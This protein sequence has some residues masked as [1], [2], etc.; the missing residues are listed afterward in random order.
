M[1]LSEKDKTIIETCYLQKG[2]MALRILKEFPRKG[3]KRSTVCDLIK[4]LRSTGSTVLV[5]DL[6]A[7]G[8]KQPIQKRIELSLMT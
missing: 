5:V 1:V 8:Q 3:W 2:W 6:E 4:K 7:G